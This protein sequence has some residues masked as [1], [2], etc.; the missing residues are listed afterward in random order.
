MEQ[1]LPKKNFIHTINIYSVIALIISLGYLVFAIIYSVSV[2]PA[3]FYVGPVVLG[4][5]FLGIMRAMKKK[6]K[7]FDFSFL[8]LILC[9]LVF[10]IVFLLV[11]LD[12][13][14]IK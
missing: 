7:G 10:L 6:S 14:G 13:W 2:S 12:Y 5:V 3:G 4:F 1:P 11:R 9:A 8:S